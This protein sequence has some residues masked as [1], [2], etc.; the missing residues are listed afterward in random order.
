M[1]IPLR[2]K[3]TLEIDTGDEVKKFD[4][5]TYIVMPKSAE[6]K[7]KDFEEKLKKETNKIKEQDSL[8]FEEYN[9]LE[10]K[11]SR[12]VEDLEDLRVFHYRV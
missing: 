6:K 1:A 12:L 3:I 9:D 8:F 2:D 4:I 5:D 7:I 11:Y 10:K